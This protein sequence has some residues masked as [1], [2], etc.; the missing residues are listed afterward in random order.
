[1]SGYG[2]LGRKAK[3]K[4]FKKE[5]EYISTYSVTTLSLVS[6]TKSPAK[7]EEHE[8]VLTK[9]FIVVGTLL[10]AFSFQHEVAELWINLDSV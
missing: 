5:R 3:Q 4:N 2:S 8:V 6:C 7:A 1:M 9:I 10:E